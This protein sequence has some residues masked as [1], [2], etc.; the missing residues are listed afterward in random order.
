SRVACSLSPVACS[1]SPVAR[2]LLPVAC[3]LLHHQPGVRAPVA[4]GWKFRGSMPRLASHVSRLAFLIAL[5]VLAQ[6]QVPLEVKVAPGAEPFDFHGYGPYR[7]QVP[8]PDSLLGYPIGTRH[9]MY[10][11]QQAVLDAMVAAAPDRARFQVTGQS[12]E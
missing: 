2:R 4:R 9:T 7:P 11:Q 1:L 10:H 5:A 8:R 3:R 12:G 6:A